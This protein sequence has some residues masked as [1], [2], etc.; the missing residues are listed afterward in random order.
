MARHS[1]YRFIDLADEV[2]ARTGRPLTGEEIWE[3]AEVLGVSKKL[4]SAGKTPWATLSARLFTETIANPN[5]R[6]IRVGQRPVRFFLKSLAG[7]LSEIELEKEAHRP[8]SKESTRLRE[9]DVHPLLCYFAFTQLTVQCKTI[10]HERSQKAKKSEW[11]HPDLVGLFLPVQAWEKE[12]LSL[13]QSLGS[14]IAKLYGFELKLEV[15]FSN[16]RESF[17]QAVSNTS[18]AN[19]GYLVATRFSTDAEFRAELKRL[20]DAFR[21]GIIRLDTRDPDASEI[22]HRSQEKT[23]LDWETINKLTALNPDFKRFAQVVQNS[24]RI[25]EIN[26]SDF[27]PV[28]DDPDELAKSLRK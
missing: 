17:F 22:V 6:F 15:D 2:L 20:S 1:G 14:P 25:H 4:N 23:E 28:P 21:I 18:W 11:L 26:K 7:T 10:R 13:G 8:E 16:L 19:E 12:T 5:S 3:H 27:D 24:L 9:R